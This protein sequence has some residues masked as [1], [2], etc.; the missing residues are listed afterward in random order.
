MQRRGMNRT[1][2]CRNHLCGILAQAHTQRQ[3]PVAIETLDHPFSCVLAQF[4][5]FLQDFIQII[6][7][8]K[9]LMQ[10]HRQHFHSYK[11]F[12]FSEGL[13]SHF[14]CIL[15]SLTFSPLFPLRPRTPSA[16]CD[17][18]TDRSYVLTWYKQDRLNCREFSPAL[19]NGQFF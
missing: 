7:S 12:S 10:G 14:L 4:R 16:P 3:V 6:M 9:L 18:R 13:R 17:A 19:S 8:T 1:T 11:Q 15:G 5:S 2:Q